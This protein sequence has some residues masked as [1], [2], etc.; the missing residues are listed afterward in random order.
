LRGNVHLPSD[1]NVKGY[2]EVMRIGELG[3][4]VVLSAKTIRYYED[5]G[6]LPEPERTASGYRDYD[7]SAF[8]RLRF[9]RAAQAVGFTL[10]EIKEVLAFGDRGEAPC[11][12][13]TQLM[14][15]RIRTLSQH[16]RGLQ[17]MRG[18]LEQLVEKARALPLRHS[19]TFCHIIESV[20]RR[21]TERTGL[22][23]PNPLPRS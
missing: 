13:V 18:E 20:G 23:G 2:P 16:I 4:R 19:G 15:E 7:E 10:G 9:I 8:D 11:M 21:P 5:I 12:H 3:E 17:R 1:W 22:A 14:E 6:I